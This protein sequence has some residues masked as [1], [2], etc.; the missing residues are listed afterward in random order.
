MLET[1]FWSKSIMFAELS[2]TKSVTDTE[3]WLVPQTWLKGNPSG[4]DQPHQFLRHRRARIRRLSPRCHPVNRSFHHRYELTTRG[5]RVPFLLTIC[6]LHL[7]NTSV[8]LYIHYIIT[9]VQYIQH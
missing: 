1:V 8:L 5:H 9:N 6:T 3:R 4:W 2:W 7:V